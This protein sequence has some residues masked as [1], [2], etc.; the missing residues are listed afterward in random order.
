VNAWGTNVG[1]AFFAVGSLLYTYLLLKARSI[2][3]LKAR[4]IPSLYRFSG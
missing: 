4:S 3:L 1:A 2:L